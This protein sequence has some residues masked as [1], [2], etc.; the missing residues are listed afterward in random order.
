MSSLTKKITI[1]L[2]LAFVSLFA[3]AAADESQSEWWFGKSITDF[4]YT[5]LQ[6]VSQSTVNSLL[7]KYKNQ[8]FTPALATEIDTELYAQNW[9]DYYI[10]TASTAE[11]GYSLILDLEIHEQAM[12]SNV[13]F[14]GNSEIKSRVLIGEQDI[15]SGDFFSPGLLRANATALQDYYVSKGYRDATV[16][17]SFT[18]D[19]EKNTVVVK[20]T[21]SEGSQYKINSIKFV[22]VN[23]VAEK[24]LEKVMSSKERSFFRSGNFVQAT[25]D[26]DL[27]KIISLYNE[28]GFIDAAITSTDIV[29]VTPA[30]SKFNMLDITI[31]VNEGSQWLLGNITFEGNQV[32]SDET[33]QNAIYL[34]SGSIHN[35]SE[36]S[37]Q[38]DAIASLY[39]NDGYI[40]TG[41]NPVATRNSETHRVDY[42]IVITESAQSVVE[43]IIITGLE[44]TKPYVLERELEIKV[45]DVFSRALVQQSMQNIM[46][47]SIVTNVNFGLYQGETTNGVVLEFAVEE[48][49]QMELQFGAT[50]GGTVDGFPV[51]G[52]LQWSDK[53]LMGTGRD[54]AVSTTL[55]PDTQSLSLSLSDDWVGNKRWSNG[56]SVSFERSAK[57]SALQLG[58][59]SELYDGW[60]TDKTT[61]PLGYDSAEAWYGSNQTYPNSSYLMDYDFYRI[62][63]GYNTGYTWVFSAGSLTLGTGLSIG[64]NHAVYDSAI[65]HPYEW[66]INEYHDG[67]KFSNKLSFSV[68]W[69][70]RDLK[71]NTTRGYVLSSS[72]TYAGGILGGLSNYN[73][74]S[75]SAAGYHSIF[76][77]TNDEGVRKDFVLSLTSQV[78]FMFGQYWN[79]QNKGWKW[80]TPF[81]GTISRYETLYIDGM[82][83]GRGFSTIT[84]L[85]L[86]WHNQLELS[87]PI[88]KNVLN[89]ELYASATAAPGV[90][91]MDWSFNNLDWYFSMGGGIKLK[92]P[93]FP[94]GL[95]LVKASS[96][97]DDSFKWKEGFLPGGLDLVLAITT[98]LY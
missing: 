18:S 78:N 51:S 31:S 4:R 26:S 92:V 48:G 14:E 16:T 94:L 20:Y 96:Y 22:G 65:Y 89:A 2:L 27:N 45:G 50:F 61:F 40:Q 29:D 42:N 19:E 54:F 12:V 80:Y 37:A 93:G 10:M 84:G 91:D 70:G 62:S 74:L 52:F 7:K 38:I 59:G 67:W 81:E 71:E 87:Y 83:V 72:Y 55:S 23:G 66:I 39:Y 60:D 97:I 35:A 53:N 76:G 82:N 36:V 64:L 69:D 86:L 90:K 77:Y 8:E 49:N 34:K 11:D 56:I 1:L 58:T 47:T 33:I 95:Y 79:R 32:F 25:L 75:F 46:N 13:T 21:I 44:K 73:R 98:S 30:D 24:E 63:L 15:N 68:T 41:I 57:S 17:S 3:I 88:V 9:M 85:S 28:N 43:K 6:N 5:G